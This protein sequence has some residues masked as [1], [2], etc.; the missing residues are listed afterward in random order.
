[1]TPYLIISKGLK[2]IF[3]HLSPVTAQTH[4]PYIENARESV[5]RN[6]VESMA[7]ATAPIREICRGDAVTNNR[8]TI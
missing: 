1:M 6:R 5:E 4:H 2:L 3:C 7:R 8:I